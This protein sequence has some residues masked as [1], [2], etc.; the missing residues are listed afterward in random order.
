MTDRSIACMIVTHLPVK[1]EVRR[2]PHLRGKPV[3]ITES[4]GSKDLVL[5]SSAD[6]H[7]V[8]AGMPLSEAMARCKDAGLVQAAAPYY[9][10][11]FNKLAQARWRR[12]FGYYAAKGSIPIQGF[13]DGVQLRL[14]PG[15]GED[16]SSCLRQR[17]GQPRGL[18][19][20]GGGKDGDSTGKT[21]FR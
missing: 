2:Y 13:H 10:S 3:I 14:T 18:I 7:C 11:T 5:D 19:S 21:E 1:A 15:H 16:R 17:S 4:Y 6:A 9:N 20:A 8:N 12:N